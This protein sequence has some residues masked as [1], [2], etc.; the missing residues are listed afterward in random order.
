MIDRLQS[1]VSVRIILALVAILAA[2][3]VIGPGRREPRVVLWAWERPEDLSMVDPR[4]TSLAV[5]SKS[6]ELRHSGIIVRPRLNRLRAP[7]G[8]E[9]I[10]VVRIDSDPGY[11]APETERSMI[12]RE[13]GAALP[14]GIR[15]LQVDYDARLSERAFYRDLLNRVRREI[16]PQS[17]LT[18]TALASWCLDDPWIRDLP[19]DEAVPMLFEM[20]R[21]YREVATRLASGRDF[22]VPSCRLSVGLSV[23]EP[24]PVVPPGRT[25]YFFSAKPWSPRT[26]AIVDNARILP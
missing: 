6:I 4:S 24:P 7:A 13:I 5:L 10:A 8:I 1:P 11:L 15:T 17:R 3:A 22:K 18:I 20:G 9:T 16:P 14:S 19:I 23:N 25:L 12:A 2:S 21:D 26:L